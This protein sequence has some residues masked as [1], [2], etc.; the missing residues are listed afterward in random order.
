MTDGLHDLNICQVVERRSSSTSI[1][2][3]SFHGIKKCWK[4]YIIVTNATKYEKFPNENGEIK[5]KYVYINESYVDIDYV[6]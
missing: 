4:C 6:R 5:K 3:I 1:S 2:K